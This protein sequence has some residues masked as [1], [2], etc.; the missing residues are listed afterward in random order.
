MVKVLFV[1]TGNICRSPTA[2]G[3]LRHKVK[4][5]GLEREW[6]TDSAGIIGLHQG[7]APDP[8]TI[9]A[10]KRRGYDLTSLRARQVKELDFHRFDLL[11]A[12]D[13][14]HHKELIHQRPKDAHS[15]IALCMEYAPYMGYTEVPDPYYGSTT[16]FE[17]VLDLVE[18]AVEGLVASLRVK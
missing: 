14:G 8:R 1:C 4:L 18:A 12:M 10:A 17:R 5:L 6:E 2:E 11:I 9:A 7:E 15:T 3:V 13:K 16:D